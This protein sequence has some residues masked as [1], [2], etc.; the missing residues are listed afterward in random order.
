[1]NVYTNSGSYGGQIY[2]SHRITDLSGNGDVGILALSTFNAGDPG[3]ICF[4]TQFNSDVVWWISENENRF[5]V[6]K[7]IKA[8][9]GL[10]ATGS[11]DITG[12]LTVN[13]SAIGGPATS[14]SFAATASYVNPLDQELIITGSIQNN[15]VVPVLSGSFPNYTAS[16]DCSAGNIFDIDLD[17]GS[18][19]H[20]EAN[21]LQKGQTFML[22][23][24]QSSDGNGQIDWG[25]MFNWP[26]GVA[27]TATQAQNTADVY[28][29]VTFDTTSV[30]A[31]QS[32]DLK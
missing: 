26:A 11:V 18:T 5:H 29:F 9:G 28:T 31:I 22:R 21:N 27:P 8:I 3:R 16:I 17:N 19:Y 24:P 14:A 25:S 15:V 1:M 2:G 23:T 30:Y 7:E 32:A 12:S 6:E 4:E 10:Q 20:F 13:G